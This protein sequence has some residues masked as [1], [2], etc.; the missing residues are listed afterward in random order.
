M[1]AFDLLAKTEQDIRLAAHPRYHFEMAMLKWMHLRRLVPLADLLD[2]LVLR[3]WRRVFG[4]VAGLV[5]AGSLDPARGPQHRCLVRLAHPPCV[6]A[7]VFRP[8]RPRRRATAAPRPRR[9]DPAPQTA[10]APSSP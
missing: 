6:R 7:G 3:T 4:R 9:K 8:G 2:Q 10:A 1:R 5:G